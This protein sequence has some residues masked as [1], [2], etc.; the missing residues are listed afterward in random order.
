MPLKKGSS[1]K[2]ISQNIRTEMHHGKPQKQAVAIALNT[3]R[4]SGA[5]IPKKKK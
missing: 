2:T 5:K 4:K 1:K 3:A